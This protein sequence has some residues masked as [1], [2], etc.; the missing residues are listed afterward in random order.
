MAREVGPSHIHETAELGIGPEL[1]K[2]RQMAPDR[3][4]LQS[5][6]QAAE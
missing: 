4:F 6:S 2:Q 5:R 3:G 1:L